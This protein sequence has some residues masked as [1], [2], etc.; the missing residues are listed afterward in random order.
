MIRKF[1]LISI[2]VISILMLV[3][4][5]NNIRTDDEKI[6]DNILKS[7]A[8]VE[9]KEIINEETIDEM[10]QIEIKIG[11]LSYKAVLY[12]NQSGKEFIKMLP[13]TVI[14]NELNGNEKYCYLEYDI[15]GD[16]SVHNEIHTGD[17]MLY[18]SDCLVLFYEDFSTSYSY[19]KLG[20]IENPEG[21]K[22]AL[23]D[24]KISISFIE[25]E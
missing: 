10:K 17:L 1:E 13:M 18:G 6:L 3:S 22:N 2:F 9:N 15:A 16:S 20:Y 5:R 4:C 19:T 14:M 21:L 7:D 8:I 24:E 12:D 23:K 11:N 25:K